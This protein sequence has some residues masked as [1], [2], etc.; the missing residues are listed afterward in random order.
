MAKWFNFLQANGWTADVDYAVDGASPS[1]GVIHRKVNLSP[2]DQTTCNLHCA[3]VRS[4]AGNAFQTLGTDLMNMIPMR[5]YTSGEPHIGGI[6]LSQSYNGT[7][8][9]TYNATIIVNFP[10]EPFER[11]W[12]FES[13]Y[14]A[15]AVVEASVGKYRH[16]GMGQLIK[17]GNWFGG[18]YY[19]GHYVNQQTGT[20]TPQSS[21]HNVGLDPCTANSGANP[22]M[23]G[24]LLNGEPF[25]HVDQSPGTVWHGFTESFT[26]SGFDRDGRVRGTLAGNGCRGGTHSTLSRLGVTGF[27]G[28]RPL[29]PI[30]VTATDGTVA[31]AAHYPLGW[32]PD[33]RI[34]SMEGSL[35]GGDE[36]TIGADTWVAF[37]VTFKSGVI[38]PAGEEWSGYYGLAYKKVTT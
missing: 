23:Y 18:E 26:T 3:F 19:Y 5:G 28:F 16:F 38:T 34:I 25:P 11:Y 22:V 17:I 27:N 30:Y 13:D 31:P 29:H 9:T 1:W 7:F 4:G 32:Q 21:N 2:E 15:H 10:P 33:V 35:E 24:R 12:F 36:F 6:E 8:S 20:N 37:P 14:Y